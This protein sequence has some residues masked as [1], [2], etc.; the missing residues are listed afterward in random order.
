MILGGSLPTN[1]I[2][3]PPR[4]GLGIHKQTFSHQGKNIVTPKLIK[5]QELSPKFCLS[6]VQVYLVFWVLNFVKKFS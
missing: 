3:N 6:L 1:I 5:L 2:P 4:T